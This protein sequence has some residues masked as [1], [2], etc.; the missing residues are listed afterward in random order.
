MA[1][2][3]PSPVDRIMASLA[4]NLP[5]RVQR[6]LPSRL[7]VPLLDRRNRGR[8]DTTSHATWA[9]DDEIVVSAYW[10]R[11]NDEQGPAISVHFRAEE[12]LRIDCLDRRPHLHY[13]QVES[14][15][16]RGQGRIWLDERTADHLIE[17]AEYELT[18][19]LDF[20][21]HL[22]RR[23]S[24]Q[25]HQLP[26]DRLTEVGAAAAS[27]LRAL[28]DQNGFT[29]VPGDVTGRGIDSRGDIGPAP[30]IEG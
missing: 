19:N 6:A 22:V 16:R 23:R 28:V 24:V 18:H 14:R 21:L 7:A 17:R 4:R 15:A 2:P 10:L 1:F 8:S 3:R 12:I 13:C 30:S 29:P 5:Y 27:H 20:S 25:R 9:V 11:V 26:R